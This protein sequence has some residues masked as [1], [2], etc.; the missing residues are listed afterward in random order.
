M[1]LARAAAVVGVGLAAALATR[2]LR[3]FPWS[4]AGIAG[5]AAAVLTGM[6]LRTWDQLVKVWRPRGGAPPDDPTGPA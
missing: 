6:S 4:L 2:Y 5:L 3:A 1:S